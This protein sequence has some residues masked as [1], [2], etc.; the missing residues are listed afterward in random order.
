MGSVHVVT[1]QHLTKTPFIDHYA[2]M[3]TQENSYQLVRGEGRETDHQM[4]MISIRCI[5]FKNVL[6]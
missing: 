2:Q 1:A 5:L 6:G 3:L 4:F